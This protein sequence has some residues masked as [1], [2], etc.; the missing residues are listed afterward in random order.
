RN[1]IFKS[2]FI[3]YTITSNYYKP[4]D[5]FFEHINTT[6]A[7]N[8]KNYKNSTYDI[9]TIF[10]RPSLN[11]NYLSIIGKSIER[12]F[13]TNQ[14]GTYTSSNPITNITFY[15]IKL[16]RDSKIKRFSKLDLRA[17]NTPNI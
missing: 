13:N 8:I 17:F 9:H 16:Y 3:R 15:I 14:N 2:S 4:I 1:T 5:L 10:S 6:Y 11:S 7:I 12:F